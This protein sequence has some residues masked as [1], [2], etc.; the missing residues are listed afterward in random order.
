VGSGDDDVYALN[1]TTS[2]LTQAERLVWKYTTGGTVLSSPA[3][4]G[5]VVY[6]GD[7]NG[8]VY[9]LN[10]TTGELMPGWPFTGG[11]NVPS[12]PA[13]VGGVVYVGTDNAIVYAL[14]ATTGAVIWS[15]PTG[16]AVP[17]SPAV[18]GGVVYVGSEDDKVYALNASATTT[19]RL[20]WTY[21][22]GAGVGFSC[23][24]VAS[25]V[26]FIGSDD[27]NVY[28][29]NATTGALMW[30]YK[31]GGMVE[32]SPVVANGEVYV[33]S[34]DG[35]VYAFGVHD[36][37]VTDV[38]P[39]KTVVGRGLCMS[40]NVA[41]A[42]LGSYLETFA[43]WQFG[44]NTPAASQDIALMPRYYNTSN[45]NVT[46]TLLWNTTGFAKGKYTIS[47][48]AWL[49]PG[50]IDTANN[51]CVAGIP[52]YVAMVGD[53]TGPKGVPDGRVD[54]YDVALFAESFGSTPGSPR[55]NPNCDL[56]GPKGVPDGHV[57][58]DDI[59]LVA[60]MFGKRD[61]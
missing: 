23:P 53:I 32:S 30:K 34:E 40:V 54:M 36:V 2:P 21:A 29:L 4:S 43:I 57:K 28:A 59:A 6:V 48:L 17:C 18:V 9:A 46:V 20:L 52:V 47:T 37:A 13:V 61:P 7:H 41:V 50:E 16:G 27:D 56:T 42:N 49:V 24:A 8:D 15:Y 5:G 22:T 55:W 11:G 26:V 38:V 19:K 33:G 14:N 45:Y 10:A 35:K 58:M 39:S 60:G 51:T 1:A 44:N 3:V 25:G 31:T 12:S